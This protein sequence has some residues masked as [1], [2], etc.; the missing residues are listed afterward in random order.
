M[1][2]AAC[3]PW[4]LLVS[5]LGLALP[6]QAAPN[7]PSSTIQ[8]EVAFASSAPAAVLHYRDVTR[9]VDA[10]AESEREVE[11]DGDV[12]LFVG[13]RVDVAPSTSSCAARRPCLNA[14][15]A[16]LVTDHLPRSS[17]G[18]PLHS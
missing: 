2:W 11:S 15:L 6:I 16:E 1:Q 3:T 9:W 10:D 14:P 18:P 13:L 4:L 5:S 7:S 12:D 17:R 8:G